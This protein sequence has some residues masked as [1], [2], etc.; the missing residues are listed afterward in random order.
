MKIATNAFLDDNNRF[1]TIILKAF[2]AICLFFCNH[3]NQPIFKLIWFL[4]AIL[5]MLIMA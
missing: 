5:R 3:P 2:V 1:F 4:L